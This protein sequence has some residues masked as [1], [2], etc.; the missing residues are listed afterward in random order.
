MP[1][2]IY[3]HILAKGAG[4]LH[5]QNV[6]PTKNANKKSPKTSKRLAEIQVYPEN[7][8]VRWVVYIGIFPVSRLSGVKGF[9]RWV[10]LPY[11]EGVPGM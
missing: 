3:K 9:P 1:P 7:V 2:S 11:L 5:L 8:A 10:P 6:P 4:F